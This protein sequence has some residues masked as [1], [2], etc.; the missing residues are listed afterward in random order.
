MY[1]LKIRA[2]GSSS[3]AVF[4]KELLAELGVKQGDVLYATRA[5]DGSVR[6]TPH[7]ETFA[8]QMAV[9]EEV[10]REDRDILRVL[11]TR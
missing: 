9:A 10:M 4:P 7:D 1:A 2:V 6:L 8:R 11:A 3:G 5:P